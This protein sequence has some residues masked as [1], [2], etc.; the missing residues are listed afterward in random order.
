ML[1][2]GRIGTPQLP[3]R[4]PGR[5]IDR[6]AGMRAMQTL[7]KLPQTAPNSAATAVIIGEDSKAAI[8]S[9]TGDAKVTG[10]LTSKRIWAVGLAAVS[11]VGGLGACK[12][13]KN[14]GTMPAQKVAVLA[15]A[16][17]P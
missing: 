16:L 3:Q 9:M 5:T 15:D 14:H 12:R 1:S 4:D 8:S 10:A 17:R 7:K 11:A 6:P 13:D 2:D